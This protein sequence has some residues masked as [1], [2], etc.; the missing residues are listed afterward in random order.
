MAA[1]SD[2]VII[3]CAVTGSMHT[4]TISEA[5]PITPDQLAEPMRERHATQFE[6]ASYDVAHL[7][8]RGHCVDKGWVKPAIFLQ[9]IFGSLGGIGA[10]VENRLFMKRTADA[11]FGDDYSWSVRGAGRF[12]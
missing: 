4:P 7:Y 12:Q 2:K 5:L 9:L 10:D 3:T 6:H 11:L 1:K 8:N